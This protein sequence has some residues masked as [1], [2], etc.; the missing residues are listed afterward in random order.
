MSDQHA[1]LFAN[2]AFYAA[3]AARDVDAM[4]AIWA[5]SDAV[6]CI[7]P[8][9]SAL[10]GREPV[11]A[12]WRTILSNPRAPRISCHNPVAHMLDSVGYVIC[13]EA[14]QEGFLVAT[15]IFI[16]ESGDWKLLHH[17]A[18]QCPAPDRLDAAIHPLQ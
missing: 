1:L 4:D 7:H 13:L 6:S 8:G 5:A 14:L 16:R 9:W 12:S 17:Q 2:A 3:F 18:G 11:M 15:N 10:I